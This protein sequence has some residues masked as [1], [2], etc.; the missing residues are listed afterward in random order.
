MK[1]RVLVG[2][3]SWADKTL[4]E[5]GW[6]PPHVRTPA[7]RLQHYARHFP[8]VEVDSTYYALPAQRQAHLWAARTP[9]GFVFDVK[10][11]ALFTHHPTPPDSLPQDVRQALPQELRERRHIY[12]RDL[13]SELRQ[14]L[15][16]RFAEALLP[17]HLAGKLGVVLF[18]FPPWF[19]PSADARRHILE[20][21]ERLPHYTIAVEFRQARWLADEE[22]RARTLGFLREHR[23]PLVCVDEPQGFPSSVPPLA[24]VTA[25]LAVV[26]FHGRNAATWEAKGIT[27]AERFNYLYSPEELQEWVPRIGRLAQEAE[28]VHVL[29][30]NCYR[31]YS[32]RNAR[33]MAEALGLPVGKQGS[34]L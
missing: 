13:P 25:P 33:Q 12:Y 29:F 4:L 18:Q 34:L 14:E 21:R 1:A 30:N 26:R 9:P 7:Q 28:E 19:G 5:A 20:A 8:I 6:Y 27:A 3:C 10:A 15:W 11:F 31:D 22:N 23:L 32:V 2:T 24:E 16:R 17:L